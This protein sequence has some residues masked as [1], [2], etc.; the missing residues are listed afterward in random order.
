M[1]YISLVISTTSAAES[2]SPIPINRNDASHRFKASTHSPGF[3]GIDCRISST[4]N[5]DADP[6]GSNTYYFA[7]AIIETRHHIISYCIISQTLHGCGAVNVF[8]PL[9]HPRSLSITLSRILSILSLGLFLLTLLPPR[10]RFD[11]S[12]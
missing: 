1:G 11:P 8:P 12:N 6:R 7:P 9:D 10:G 5:L 3:V 2:E 4:S